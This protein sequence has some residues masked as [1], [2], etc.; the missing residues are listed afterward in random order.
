[1]NRRAGKPITKKVTQLVNV[2]EHVE[3]FARCGKRIAAS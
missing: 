3:G 1:M 2:E